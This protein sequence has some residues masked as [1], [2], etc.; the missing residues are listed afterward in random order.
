[1]DFAIVAENPNDQIGGGGCLCSGELKGEDCCGPFI[2]FPKSEQVSSVSPHSVL[3]ARCLG[4][5]RDA[6][7]DPDTEILQPTTDVISTPE[8]GPVLV[9][10]IE[11]AEYVGFEQAAN[12]GER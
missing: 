11:S 7:G 4:Q 5:V 6:L 9:T 1:M 12:G 10:S 8:D 3:C 2:V